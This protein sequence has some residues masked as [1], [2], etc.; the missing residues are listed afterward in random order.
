MRVN[1]TR[2]INMAKEK[3]KP[4]W[5]VESYQLIDRVELYLKETA[6]TR[7][8]IDFYQ[9]IEHFGGI[10]W[11]FDNHAKKIYTWICTYWKHRSWAKKIAKETNPKKFAKRVRDILE[12]EMRKDFSEYEIIRVEEGE[13]NNDFETLFLY[14]IVDYELY[15]EHYYRPDVQMRMPQETVETEPAIDRCP[16]CDWIISA[17]TTKCPK[18]QKDVE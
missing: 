3:Y 16:H 13:I 17:G 4:Q 9:D 8:N 5:N 11:Y 10:I 2:G 7:E 1:I 18:C 6:A 14:E 12:K 15:Q